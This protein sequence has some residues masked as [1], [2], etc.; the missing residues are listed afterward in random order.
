MN[1]IINECVSIDVAFVRN[2]LTIDSETNGGNGRNKNG[3][4]TVAWFSVK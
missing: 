1:E 3:M 2:E 4:E